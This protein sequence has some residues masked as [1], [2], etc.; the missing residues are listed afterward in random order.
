MAFNQPI[1]AGV[2]GFTGRKP[3]T[4]AALDREL[5]VVALA[6]WSVSETIS[7]LHDYEKILLAISAVTQNAAALDFKRRLAQSGFKSLS[8]ES[9]DPRKF[10]ETNA[11]DCF[12]ALVAD[13]LFP[14]RTLEG[15]IQRSLILYEEGFQIADPMD[16]FEEIT[17]YKLMQ[18]IL[19]LEN[20][21]STKELQ[22]L[23]SA[24]VAWM[25]VHRPSHVNI[26]GDFILPNR[27]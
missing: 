23:I 11:Q 10:V 9:A 4:F 19:P 21:Y 14:R 17:R 7:C 22:A 24:Y 27:E 12:R 3:V 1:F 16:F 18:G 13:E 8:K 6:R 25:S 2:D 20:L 5:N 15:R 26:Q